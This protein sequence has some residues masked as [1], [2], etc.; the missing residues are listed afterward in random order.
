MDDPTRILAPFSDEVQDF[1]RFIDSAC[2]DGMKMLDKERERAENA[3]EENWMTP[4]LLA[5]FNI[6]RA[7]GVLFNR[8]V[9]AGW[10]KA[11]H[12]E[13]DKPKIIL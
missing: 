13:A 3:K 10:I 4:D 12:L 2:A 8:C 9:D 11:V 1:L 7:Y 5:T 6:I